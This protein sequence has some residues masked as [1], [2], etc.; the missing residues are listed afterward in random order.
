[1]FSR[2]LLM[3]VALVLGALWAVY[4][5]ELFGKVDFKD[6]NLSQTGLFGDSFGVFSSL[7]SGL[8][9]V[10]VLYT[11][12]QQGQE[13][14]L[15]REEMAKNVAAQIRQLH[16][17]LLQ[18]AV[19]DQTNTLEKVW[20]ADAANASSD[21][22]SMY[23]NLILS[24]WEMQFVNQLLSES[25]LQA[26]LARYMAYP[27][28]RAFW[29]ANSNYRE[30]MAEADERASAFHKAAHAAYVAQTPKSAASAG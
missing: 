23:V 30:K 4:G 21:K 24:H 2:V 9:L 26:M 15:Q 20:S 29:H 7:F 27:H 14:R 16:F 8:A 18:L 3:V 1:M 25:Q 11:V 6:V 17:S 28:F 19:N 10:G 13:L 12:L 5:V 22:Q